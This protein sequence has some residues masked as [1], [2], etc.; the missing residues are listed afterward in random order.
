M[1]KICELF[2]V[3]GNSLDLEETLSSFDQE[4]R[5]LLGYEALSLHLVESGRLRPA[6]AAGEEFH[7]LAS[8]EPAAEE[9]FLGLAA[10]IRQPVLNCRPERLGSL[11]SALV[12]PLEH[13]GAVT[14]V[15][16]IYHRG[17]RIFSAAD[18]HSL[19]AVAPKLAAAIEN[20]R[21]YQAASQ[22]AG[23]D[24]LTGVLNARTMFQR[25]DAELA[26]TRRLGQPLAVL[27]CAIL[28]LEECAPEQACAVRRRIGVRLREGCREY[29]AVARTGD[30]FVLVLPGFTAAG[31]A[32]KRA[33]IQNAVE[34]AGAAAGLPLRAGVGAA[35]FPED[36]SDTEGLLAA[37]AERLPRAECGA[38]GGEDGR[39]PH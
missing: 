24:P 12:V 3:L 32:E 20:A 33:R 34:E 13:G 26:R 39:T 4:L 10:R 14:A 29:D 1:E 35:F 7:I 9:G 27:E 30:D 18:L 5:G 22:L 19:L 17:A 11:A 15:L 37:A 38:P 16:A 21:T 8:L 28:G 31:L 23:G 36:G 2:R 6:Y 25:L